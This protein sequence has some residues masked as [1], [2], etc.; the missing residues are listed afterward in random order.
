M[1]HTNIR[2]QWDALRADMAALDERAYRAEFERGRRTTQAQ[3]QHA[4]QRGRLH[5]SICMGLVLL[6]LFWLC[7]WIRR[8]RP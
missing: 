7:L 3:T 5:G 8:S 6:G 1:S 4:Y 2:E